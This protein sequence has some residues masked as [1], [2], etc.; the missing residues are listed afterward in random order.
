VDPASAAR[1]LGVIEQR[2]LTGRNGATWQIGTV[3]RLAES[4]ATRPEALRQMTQRYIEHMHTN[5]P[6]HAWPVGG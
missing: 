1:L 3:A 6:A 5:E 4:G 2:C